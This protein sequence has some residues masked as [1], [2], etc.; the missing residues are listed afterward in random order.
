MAETDQTWTETDLRPEPR[1]WNTASVPEAEAFDYYREGICAAFM[2]L[3]PELA[4]GRRH[5]FSAE[6][7]SYA[8]DG[9][10]L[11]LVSARAH[12]VLR[13][14]SE[15]AAS[16]QDCYYLNFQLGGECRIV[17]DGHRIA[18]RAGEVG[19]FDS[20]RAF[21]LDHDQHP[22]LRVASLMVPKA[23]MRARTGADLPQA[24]LLLSRH[25]VLGPLVT[26]AAR[27]LA[28]AVA[29]A[30]EAE[31]AR[32]HG[33]L[34]S[35]TA[36]AALPAGTEA[37]P[38]K[39]VE[40]RAAAQLA[41]IKRIVRHRCATPGYSVAACAAEAGMTP[42]SVHRLF[43]R[44]ADSFGA[45]LL[46]E[47][48]QCAARLLRAPGQA[49]MPVGSIGYAAGFRDPS[50]FARAFRRQYGQSPGTWRRQDGGTAD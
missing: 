6:I 48:L 33:I 3:R 9:S 32:L 17:Q 16:P 10:V 28:E 44:E 19:I 25:P 46:R 24:P 50:H 43:A 21:D 20:G 5:R 13:R 42:R 37:A 18:L 1:I 35:L 7:A 49:H 39:A 2:P 30:P 22:A 45:F 36:L 27:S 4:R 47:R 14:R 34:L 8:V 40:S 31:L 29:W 41:R 11:N 12:T 15:I 26:E 23:L 38:P